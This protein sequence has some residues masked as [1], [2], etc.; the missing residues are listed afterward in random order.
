MDDHRIPVEELLER[1]E[2][3]E[4]RGLTQNEA[5]RRNLELGDNKLPE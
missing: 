4:E 5:H 3:N 2:S 1:L